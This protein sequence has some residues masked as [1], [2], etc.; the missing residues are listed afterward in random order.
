MTWKNKC[1]IVLVIIVG[2]AVIYIIQKNKPCNI[3]E[4]KLKIKLPISSEIVEFYHNR[5]NEHFKAKILIPEQGVE[6]LKKQLDN[7]FYGE[8]LD[9]TELEGYNFK[10][11]CSWWD[12][13][14]NDIETMYNIMISGKR[15]FFI[16]PAPKTINIWAFISKNKDGQYYLYIS[17]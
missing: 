12:L 10:S 15:K 1:F 6:D 16:L 4:S 14:N 2:V 11:T 7:F 5:S 17:Y 9:K 13:D 8:V 3:I